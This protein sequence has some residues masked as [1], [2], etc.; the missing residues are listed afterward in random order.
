MRDATYTVLATDCLRSVAAINGLSDRL[1]GQRIAVTGGFGFVGTWIA[2]TVAAL[3]ERFQADIRLNLLGREPQKWR[4]AQPGL[5]RA[6]ILCRAV[7]V[8]ASFEFDRDTTLVIHAA[9]IADPRVQASAPQRVYQSTLFG[10][11]NAL[12]A[13]HR[14]ENIQRFV[15]MG[16]GQVGGQGASSARRETE[17]G[18][19]DF[20]RLH[21]LY[22]ETHRAAEAI[23]N[24]FA[25]QYRLPVT[26][27]RPF[28]FLGP[29]QSLDAPWAVNNFIRDAL[30]GH[31]IRVHG[32]GS[33]LRS[34]LYGSDAAAW[35]LQCALAGRDGAVYNI[36][37]ATPISHLQTASLVSEMTHPAPAVDVRS[38]VTDDSRSQDFYPDITAITADLGVYATVDVKTAIGRTLHWHAEAL[39]EMRRLRQAELPA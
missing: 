22:A 12:S 24:S 15:H 20:R 11:D 17:V 39:G 38:N 5:N 30:A 16:S 2:T 3:N 7:D 4:Q 6:D 28:T 31:E 13:A 26:T 37:G 33:S 27:V 14:L 23:A 35:L 19:L 34:Y 29:F 32:Q 10:L 21:H 36:G 18:A 1:R 9:G 25:S 8:R